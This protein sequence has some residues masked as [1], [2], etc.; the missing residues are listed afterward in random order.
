[1]NNYPS[2]KELRNFGLFIGLEGGVDGLIYMSDLSNGDKPEEILF[3][4][5][6][7]TEVF[8]Q[9]FKKHV[10]TNKIQQKKYFKD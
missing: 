7:A 8:I 9:Q 4:K 10:V 1:M 6:N 5:K 2:Q 3:W